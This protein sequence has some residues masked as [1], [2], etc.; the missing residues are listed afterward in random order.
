MA[1]KVYK[2]QE[3]GDTLVAVL[4]SSGWGAGWSTWNN[5]YPDLLFESEV[6]AFLLNGGISGKEALFEYMHKTYKGIYLG[7]FEDLFIVWAPEGREFV[8][9][10]YDGM[11]SLMFKDEFSWVKP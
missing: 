11:E 5:E 1:N 7:G 9:L 8:I 4:V 3:N 6:V 2:I 10:E